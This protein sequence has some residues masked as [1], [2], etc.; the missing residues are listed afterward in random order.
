M[1][2]SVRK[3]IRGYLHLK[4]HPPI[5]K[6]RLS[7]LLTQSNNRICTGCMRASPTIVMRFLLEL[8]CKVAIFEVTF[9][10]LRRLA[11]SLLKPI[12]RSTRG[13]AGDQVENHVKIETKSKRFCKGH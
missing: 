4:P 1:G 7:P 5:P 10:I 6:I 11:S 9:S 3:G 13:D 12:R 8:K 2:P